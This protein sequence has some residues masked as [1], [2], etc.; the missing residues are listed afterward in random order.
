[1]IHGQAGYEPL[2]DPDIIKVEFPL[3]AKH[4]ERLH[5]IR[6]ARSDAG[7]EGKGGV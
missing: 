3:Y 7:R 5:G 2:I 6:K 4:G 1:M